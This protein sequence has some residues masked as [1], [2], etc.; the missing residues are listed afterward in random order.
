[1]P[2]RR[3]LKA[4]ADRRRKSRRL[5]MREYHRYQEEI[6]DLIHQLAGPTQAAH[7][8]AF[9]LL[10]KMADAITD[11]LLAALADPGLDPIATDEVIS[12]LSGTGDVRAIEPI[13]SYFCTH[14]DDP[15]RAST[16]ALS[17]AGLG[18]E[19]VLPY[20][21]DALENGDRESVANASAG[22]ITVGGL[23]DISLLRIIHRQFK[24]DLEIRRAVTNAILTILGEANSE[25]MERELDNI[26]NSIADGDLWDDIWAELER[27][28][29][30]DRHRRRYR[31]L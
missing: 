12:L 24:A 5:A 21:R 6:P 25:T 10:A 20:L 9:R 14:G 3:V 29:G 8:R 13:W 4:A 1:M 7:D 15:D 27:A 2:N 19:R 11:D 26:E 22:M 18:D 23:E 17:L 30:P 16:A 28:F 31:H